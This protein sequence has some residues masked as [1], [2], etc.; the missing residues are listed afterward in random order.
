MVRTQQS[1]TVCQQVSYVESTVAQP[2][3]LTQFINGSKWVKAMLKF[4]RFSV[5]TFI[6]GHHKSN[7]STNNKAGF[8][9]NLNIINAKNNHECRWAVMQFTCRSWNGIEGFADST[10]GHG[11]LE[12]ANSSLCESLRVLAERVSNASLWV[13]FEC[14]QRSGVLLSK[15]GLV[16]VQTCSGVPVLD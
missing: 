5:N 10:G 4:Q 8:W 3:P 9:N 7:N 6:A 15:H 16:S 1:E 11:W 14:V 13:C 12:I 2:T